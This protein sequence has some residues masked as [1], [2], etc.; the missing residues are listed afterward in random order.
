MSALTLAYVGDAVF[1]LFVRIR[2][3]TQHD[4]KP[5][6]LTRLGGKMVSAA[7]QAAMFE[8]IQTQLA[9]DEASVAKRCRNA[10]VNNKAKNYSLAEYMKATALEGVLGYLRLCGRDER[11]QFLLERCWEIYYEQSR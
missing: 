10:H 8:I 3:A 2:L 4:F 5:G 9:A 1:T 11:L 6:E 7:A